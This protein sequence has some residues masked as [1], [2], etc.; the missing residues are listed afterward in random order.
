[1]RVI[2]ADDHDVV[3]FGI[4]VLLEAE[5][6]YQVSA[7][8]G[9]L[10]E[11][12]LLVQK[13]PADLIILDY[14]M[15]GGHAVAVTNYLKRRFPALKVLMFTAHR[16]AFIM[17]ELYLSLAD[18][19]LLKQDQASELLVALKT[20]QAGKRYI[21]KEVRHLVTDMDLDLTSREIQILH[22]ILEGLPRSIIAEQLDV[23]TETIKTHRRNLMRKLNVSNVT[24]LVTKASQLNLVG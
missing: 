3:R 20:L 5:G 1:M 18:G 12:K 8:T 10:A 17:Q 22:L 7:E 6:S 24:Q 13:V 21:S 4:R 16:S 9:D 19:I 14:K 2:I 11:L 23:S 15:P